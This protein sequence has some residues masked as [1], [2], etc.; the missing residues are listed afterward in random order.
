MNFEIVDA[1]TIPAP[2]RTRNNPLLHLVPGQAYVQIVDSANEQQ[3]LQNAL[4]AKARVARR[5]TGY[6]YR[7]T[8]FNDEGGYKVAVICSED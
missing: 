7:T 6:S 8:K 5:H 2:K 3:A 4:S 1:A